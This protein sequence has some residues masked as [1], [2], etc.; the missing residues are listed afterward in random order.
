MSKSS[1]ESGKAVEDGHEDL[2]KSIGTRLEKIRVEKQIS[3]TLL[4]D[5]VDMSRT[6]YYRMINGKVYFNT[7]KFLKMLD[8]LEKSPI[9]F[10]KDIERC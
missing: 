2:L 8:V 10:F 1:Y 7:Y 6:T 9:D 4:C 3:I 5:E